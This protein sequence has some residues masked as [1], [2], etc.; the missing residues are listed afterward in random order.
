MWGGSFIRGFTEVHLDLKGSQKSGSTG[1]LVSCGVGLS[2]GV[3]QK[4]IMTGKVPR[5]VVLQED[6]SLV[7]LVFHQGFYSSP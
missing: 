6:W 5:R 7:G 3:L 1:G 2:S 4:S